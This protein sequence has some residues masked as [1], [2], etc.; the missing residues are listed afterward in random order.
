MERLNF[1]ARAGRW[2]ARHWKSAVLAW[3]VFVAIAIIFGSMAKTVDQT[4]PGFTGDTKKAQDILKQANFEA[5][6]QES[7]LVKS[8]TLA[9]SDPAFKAVEGRV[10]TALNKQPDVQNVRSPLQVGGGGLISPS[11]HSTL[12][13]FEVKGKML[14]AYKIV[15][16]IENSVEKVAKSSPGFYVAEFGEASAQRELTDTVE[17]DFQR[18]EIRTL[19]VTIVI[20]LA[21]FGSFVAAGVPVLVAFSGVLAA[22]GLLALS[23]HL[24]PAAS[25]TKS[26]VLLVGMAVGVDYS[27]F[28]IR[29]EREERAKGVAGLAALVK[30]AGTSGMAILISGLTVFIAMAGMLLSGSNIF[31]SIGIGAMLMVAVALIGSLSILPAIMH[32]LGDRINKGRIPF[33]GRNLSVN[34]EP[35][36]WGFFLDRVLRR[37][38]LYAASSATLLVALTLPIF[39]LHTQLPS[40]TDLPQNIPIIQTYKNLQREFPGAQVPAV[41]VVKA[42]NVTAPDVQAQINKLKTRALASGQMFQPIQ[43]KISPDQTVESIAI[44]VQGDGS[45]AESKEAL[46][47]LRNKII[48]S[49]LGHQQDVQAFVTGQTAGTTDFNNSMKSHMPIVIGFVLLLVFVLLLLTFRSIVIPI[50]AVLLNLLSVGA[51]YGSLVLIFQHKWAEGILNFH[52]NGAIASWLP[53]FLFVI[54]FGLSMDYHIFILSRIKEMVD[55][56]L[57]TEAAVA[58]GIKRTA[59]V[60]TSAAIVMIAVFAIFAGLSTIDIKQMGVGLAIAIFIDATIVRAILL[61]SAMKLLGEWNWYLPKWLNWLPNFSPEMASNR[62]NDKK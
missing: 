56:G 39:K 40:F 47:T 15:K 7:V 44:P 21:A 55:N 62:L 57:N 13:T 14:D 51:A 16:P 37:P 28:Y 4:D 58:A 31:I 61:P 48:P 29:R 8:K 38:W 49:T 45:N 42:P 11:Q 19:V 20:L 53:L 50:K 5:P 18:A 17:K 3:I 27:L 2:S 30:T 6:A 9:A 54:L 24:F 35:R 25:A 33:F 23:S 32:E 60:V 1:T 22:T 43:T 46:M 52:S 10:V 41:V 12:V 36:F 59:G 26:V 34:K